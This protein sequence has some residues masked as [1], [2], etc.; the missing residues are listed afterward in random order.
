MT[1]CIRG[2]HQDD[3]DAEGQHGK[4]RRKRTVLGL[5]DGKPVTRLERVF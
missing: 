3:A 4:N 1:H 2:S 5:G